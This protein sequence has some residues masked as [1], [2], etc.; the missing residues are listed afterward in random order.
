MFD[1]R[2]LIRKLKWKQAAVNRRTNRS[3]QGKI[4]Y[5]EILEKTRSQG[6]KGLTPLKDIRYI[7][8][9]TERAR[10]RKLLSGT[11][12]LRTSS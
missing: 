11:E 5:R 12:G 4:G 2:G 7:I 3:I 1:K 10:F 6:G 8:P 9:T